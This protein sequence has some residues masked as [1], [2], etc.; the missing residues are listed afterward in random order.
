MQLQEHVRAFGDREMGGD[1]ILRVAEE[2]LG[3]KVLRGLL[4]AQHHFR[5][6]LQTG[7]AVG[8]LRFK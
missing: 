1:G 7:Q 2:A 6:H 3:P 8:E 5:A 4:E